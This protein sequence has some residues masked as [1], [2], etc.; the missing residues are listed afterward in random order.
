MA[1]WENALYANGL[2]S[3]WQN[4]WGGT[5][6]DIVQK[7]VA[8]ALG[9]PEHG[10]GNSIGGYSTPG[11]P[12]AAA[13]TSQATKDRVSDAVRGSIGSL[14]G[15]TALGVGGALAA[16]MPTGMLG[17]AIAGSLANPSNIGGV[18]GS[19]VNAAYGT[20]SSGLL[21]RALSAVPGMGLGMA[22]GPVGGLMG[23]IIG[24]PVA[25]AVMDGFDAREREHVRD[26]YEGDKL[27]SQISGRK[28]YADRIG[29]E[30]AAAKVRGAVPSSIAALHAMDQAIAATRAMEKSYGISPSYGLDPGASSKSYGGWGNIGGP[31]GGASAVGSGYG[32]SMGGFAGLGIGNPSSYGGRS[33]IGSGGSDSGGGKSSDGGGYGGHA[34]GKDGSS[35]GFGR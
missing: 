21:G 23:G 20:Q 1:G 12:G 15:K 3:P 4:A 28:A 8:P 9:M 16:G 11:D 17:S 2:M 22:F 25:D 30:Q 27:S 6:Q 18:L 19:A 10:Y 33:S 7:E 35:S 5:A 24:G 13:Q 26:D 34:G 29:I 32:P 14:A 31:S